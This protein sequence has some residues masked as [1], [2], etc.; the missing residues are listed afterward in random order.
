MTLLEWIDST[1]DHMLE[2]PAMYVRTWG[3]FEAMLYV[4]LSVRS[5]ARREPHMEI[6]D[7]VDGELEHGDDLHRKRA[8]LRNAYG[9]GSVGLVSHLM[10]G[11]VVG[12]KTDYTNEPDVEAVSNM[13]DDRYRE[14]FLHMI[15]AIRSHELRT[16]EFVENDAV[17]KDWVE[18]RL[19]AR[20]FLTAELII[21]EKKA[22][23][24]E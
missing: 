6:P 21:I 9:T 15:E 20:P 7:D 1:I 13:K 8:Y 12:Q 11:G 10:N 17:L 4:L 24:T 16:T 2:R 22:L 18:S 5:L 14:A 19:G 3:E 23:K